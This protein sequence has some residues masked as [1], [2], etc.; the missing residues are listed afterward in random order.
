VTGPAPQGRLELTW[1]NKALRLLAHEDGAYEWTDPGDYRVAEVRLLRDGDTVGRTHANEDRAA[2]NLLIRGDA[3]HGLKALRQL[4][5]FSGHYAG[6][7][8]LAYIDP[9]FNTRQA[10]ENYDDALEHSVWLTM[11]RDRLVQIRELLSAEGSVW[12]HLDD[13]EV[14][15]AR[16]VMEE[17]FGAANFVATVIWQKIH[18]RNNSAQHFSSDHD[19]LLV[20][21]KDRDSLTLNRIDRTE[22]SDK[23][24]WNPDNDPRGPWRRSDLTASHAYAEGRYEVEG[25]TGERFVPRRG[26]WWSVSRETF[27]EL[28]EDNRLWWGRDGTTFPFRKRFQS[29]L[30]GLVPTTIWLDDEVGNNREA[31]GE[32]SRLLGRDQQFATP[33][34]ERLLRK[35]VHIASQPGDVVLDCFLGSGTTAAVAHKMGRRWLGIERSW[36]TVATFAAPRLSQ[37]VAGDDPGG[38]SEMVGWAGGGGFRVLEVADSMFG[39]DGD[40]V[41]LAPWATEGALAEAVRAQGGWEASDDPPFCGRKGRTRLAVLDGLVT[42]DVVLLL[43]GWL[44]RD[45]HLVVY[46][47]AVDPAAGP[48]LRDANRGSRVRQ[49]PQSILDDYRRQ[50]RADVTEWLN[51]AEFDPAETADRANVADAT[52]WTANS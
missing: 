3:L 13:S 33:K 32:L 35:I 52:A 30:A 37:V 2:D 45:E 19:Y 22:L 34:P 51:V 17:V 47:T 44:D 24:F 23:E 31:K 11:M 8:K 29:E 7:V 9:P 42:A 38:V 6:G 10:F 26:R 46:G 49:V 1:T 18:A 25:P 28:R 14:H 39:L 41:V 12:V 4:P 40:R 21:A 27:D 48:A 5:E 16:C 20:F 50:W 36:D 43:V 15:R